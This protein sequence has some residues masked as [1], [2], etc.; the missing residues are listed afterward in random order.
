MTNSSGAYT[1]PALSAGVYTVTFSLEGSRPPRSATYGSVG[2]PTTLNAALRHREP[3]RNHHRQRRR[4]RAD[5]H[6][7]TCRNRHAECRA[8]CGDP[9][10]NAECAERGYLS[11]WCEHLGR[12]AWLDGQWPPGVV[13]QFDARRRQQQ[14]H[15]QQERRRVFLAGSARQDAVEA[16]TVTTAAGGA[17]VGGHGGVTINF[18]T[19]SGTN[20]LPAAPTNTSVTRA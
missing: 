17:E 19:R 10:A 15:L 9:N 20:R 3:S 12:H 16:V 8:D 13:P 11:R 14:R 7:H 1:V 4:C 2:M 18:V 6:H 5:Q